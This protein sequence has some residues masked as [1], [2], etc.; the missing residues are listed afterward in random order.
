MVYMAICYH[1][2]LP[3]VGEKNH[4]LYDVLSLNRVILVRTVSNLFTMLSTKTSFLSSNT[5]YIAIYL[6]ELVPFVH[7]ILPL[8]AMFTL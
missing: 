2:L 3:F 6:Q 8:F 5:V 4:N 1:E 7:E